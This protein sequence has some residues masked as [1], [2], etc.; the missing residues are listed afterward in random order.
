[1]ANEAGWVHLCHFVRRRVAYR[2]PDYHWSELWAATLGLLTFL[3]T[4]L[5]D[6]ATTGEIEALI[7]E[8]SASSSYGQLK[9][10]TL[11][12]R[13]FPLYTSLYGHRSGSCLLQKRCMSA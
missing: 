7:S 11:V 8:A 9:A 1:M 3:S 5:G 10:L 4:K 12:C 6:L 13:R 2:P